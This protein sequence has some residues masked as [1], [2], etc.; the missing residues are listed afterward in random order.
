M[1]RIATIALILS[2][3][4]PAG[5]EELYRISSVEKSNV[6]TSLKYVRQTDSTTQ[7]FAVFTMP[8]NATEAVLF[9]LPR[10]LHA[11]D[12]DLDYKMVKAH[13]V[14][15]ADESMVE[16]SVLE[17]RQNKVNFIFEFEKIPIEDKFDIIDDSEGGKDMDFRGITVDTASTKNLDPKRFLKSTNLPRC[18]MYYDE[19]NCY[20]YYLRDGVLV[21]MR[22][23]Y[24]KE[25]FYLFLTIVNNS[26]HGILF[27]TGNIRATGHKAKGKDT[28][29]VNLSLMS[30]NEYVHLIEAV[31]RYE[32][33]KA[34]ES[35]GMNEIGHAMSMASSSL[36]LST[37]GSPYNNPGYV[38]L[39]IAGGF[40][41]DIEYARK[42]PYLA[43]LDKT[44]EERTKNYLQ[45]QSIK[46]GESH[47]GFLRLEKDKRVY[48]FKV[49]IPMDGYDFDFRSRIVEQ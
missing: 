16:Y 27:N 2:C 11:T 44:R 30:K 33:N 9:N 19:G 12:G 20:T 4:V 24:A 14:P 22:S 34:S 39:G 48:D 17:G 43:E 35:K 38:G 10:T 28:T 25:H 1:K 37:F 46:P 42:K 40:L 47:S 21:T 29:V 49:I 31:D 7:I 41:R 45:S 32:A 15:I 13:N 23:T 5:A 26:D 6:N 3:L 36:A 8:E 18:G